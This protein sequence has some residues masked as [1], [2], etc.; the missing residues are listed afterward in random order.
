MSP[1]LYHSYLFIIKEAAPAFKPKPLRPT[2]NTHRTKQKFPCWKPFTSPRSSPAPHIYCTVRIQSMHGKNTD[3]R[4]NQPQKYKRAFPISTENLSAFQNFPQKSERF[5][6][7][8]RKKFHRPRRRI[9]AACLMHPPPRGK[10]SP[11]R[12]KKISHAKSRSPVTR[13]GLCISYS[14]TQT[15]GTRFRSQRISCGIVPAVAE[16]SSMVI[17]S[18]PCLPM[19]TASSPG[20]TS[21]PQA[22]MN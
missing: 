9:P 10:I 13:T 12:H 4:K 19:S 16:T 3:A 22:T 2:K 17:S 21:S 11:R 5:S 15:F 14:S 8:I 1:P 6:F 20:C 18:P 7:F